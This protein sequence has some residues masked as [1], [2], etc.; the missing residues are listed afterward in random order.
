MSSVYII[1]DNQY[2]ALGATAIL[3]HQNAV[4]VS[5]EA[6]LK[7]ETTLTEGICYIYV[8][9]RMLYRQLCRHFKFTFC[10]L[11]F[12]CRV[13]VTAAIRGY[14]HVSGLRVFLPKTSISV[15]KRYPNIS[16][17]TRRK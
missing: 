8:Q 2:F 9:D 4:I 16:N 1:T 5:I 13:F 15:Q 3:I 7:H 12:F 14:C 17:D 11:I 6:V 10:N